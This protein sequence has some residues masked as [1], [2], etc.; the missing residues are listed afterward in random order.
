MALLRVAELA[1]PADDP[2]AGLDAF[3]A[4]ADPCYANEPPGTAPIRAAVHRSLMRPEFAQRQQVLTAFDGARPVGRIVARVSS[5]LTA[6]ERRP[7]GMLGFF[8]SLDDQAIADALFRSAT[9]WLSRKGV[10]RIVGPM[11][12]D[13]WHRYRINVGPWDRPPFPLEPWNPPYYRKLWEEAGFAP[14][15]TYSSKWIDD[16]GTLLPKLESGLQRSESRGVRVRQL[17]PTRLTDELSRVHAL[18]TA[19]FSDAFLYSPIE[20]ESFL[21][22][23]AGAERFL[24]PELVL[25]ASAPDGNDVGFVFG[26]PD[27]RQG[28]VH[29]KTIG[30]LA[31]WRR[32]AVAAA[33]SHHVY[34]NAL[35]RSLPA[36]NHALMRDDNRSQA[37]DQ[38]LG[39]VFRRYVLYELPA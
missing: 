37:L 36:G 34:S 6:A 20:R 30:V 9:A 10:G 22:L 3:H 7:I 35:K 21:Q 24:D 8:E 25:F 11:D 18:S 15:E 33:L 16:V 2:S 17:D 23:Y 19:I 31:E 5:L 14:V 38:G 26:I 39:D 32:A 13:T 28:A 4:V 1:G 12:G 27:P 29:Y